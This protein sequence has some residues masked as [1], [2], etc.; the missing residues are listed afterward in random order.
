MSSVASGVAS[1]TV[2]RRRRM[3]V[4]GTELA[5]VDQ[6]RGVPVV[7]VHGS[8]SDHR[9]WES[10]RKAIS[11]HFRYVA[12]DQRYFGTAPWPDD[13][14]GFSPQAQIDDLVAVLRA[15]DAGPAHLVGWS[16]SADA[17]LGVAL[18]HPSLVRSA[19]LYEPSLRGLVLDPEQATR[20][21]ADF[22]AA[23]EPALAA[24]RSGEPAAAVRLFMDGVNDRAGSFDAMSERLR[25]MAE[26]NTRTLALQFAAPPPP[27]ITPRDLRGLGIPVAIACGG[28]TRLCYRIVAYAASRCLRHKRWAVIPGARHLWPAQEPVAFT[29]ALLDFLR[30]LPAG[31]AVK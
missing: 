29:T 26:D 11:R 15:L 3:R 21:R 27:K 31:A 20:V 14:T 1:V 16:M 30:N 18:G 10:Q 25:C 28:R 23:I 24:F 8:S 12:Y 9:L 5:C 2:T 6:G 13:G 22:R 19:F 4:N 17:V 7:F